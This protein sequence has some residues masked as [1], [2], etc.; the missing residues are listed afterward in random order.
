VASITLDN[1]SK[2]YGNSIAV[3][4]LNLEVADGELIALLGPSGCGKTTTLR[5]LAGFVSPDFG[6][7]LVDGRVVSERQKTIPPEKRN[8]SM[9][10]QSY[11]IWPHK[12]IF[13]NVAFGL[14]L[15][16]IRKD[17]LQRRV[18]QALELTYLGH[19]AERYPA[20]LSG[21]QQ[22]RVALARAIVINPQILL[23]DEPL[24]NLDANLREEMRNEI[25]RIHDET[26]LTTVYVTHDQREALIVADRIVVMSNGVLQQV[27]TPEEVYEKPATEFVARFIGRCNVLSGKLL[28]SDRVDLG[29]FSIVAEDCAPNVTVGD[30]VALSIRPH[31]IVVKPLETDTDNLHPNNFIASIERHDYSGEFREYLVRLDRSEIVLSIVTASTTR[32]RVGDR[33]RL[34]IPPASC[35]VIPC[36]LKTT[37]ERT[38][39]LMTYS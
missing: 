26:G 15:R 23:M 18:R 29:N 8:M 31:S 17:E 4:N 35:R 27:G 10:F 22:Q 19:L 5:M 2:Y 33:L 7:I 32:Y 34:L 13:E 25:K 37:V 1:L 9:I 11:A 38:A 30:E 20:Q 24:S 36:N 28:S 39:M 3:K 12:T 21:G 14:Q 16:K 6:Q